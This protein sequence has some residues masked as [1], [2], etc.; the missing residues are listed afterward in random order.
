MTSPRALVIRDGVR[1]RI[2]GREVVRGDAVVVLEGD[3]EVLFGDAVRI[4][5]LAQKAG[6]TQVAIAAERRATK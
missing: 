6:A 2:P 1:K 4:L 3:R 5:S